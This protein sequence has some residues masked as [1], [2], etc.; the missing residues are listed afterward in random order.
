V[1]EQQHGVV[2]IL[3]ANR[4][5]L[6]D[7]AYCD[8][9]CLVN[10]LWRRNRILL[11]VAGPQEG[12]QVIKLAIFR[13]NGWGCGRQLLA[14]VN[15]P[16]RPSVQGHCR[17]TLWRLCLSHESQSSSRVSIASR[18]RCHSTP[19]IRDFQRERRSHAPNRTHPL[20]GSAFSP[21]LLKE[22]CP[23]YMLSGIAL[24]VVCSPAV[25]N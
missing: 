24:G 21:R 9:A 4:N 18:T 25:C 14:L 13:V 11:R 10:A 5:P 19:I 6:F 16:K 17:L 20:S 3:A 12:S 23:V 1:Q 15:L 2:T 7:A 8:E 22:K